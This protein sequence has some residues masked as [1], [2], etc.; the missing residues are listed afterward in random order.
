MKQ[1]NLFSSILVLCGICLVAIAVLIAGRNL[2]EEYRAGE[3]SADALELLTEQ[4]HAQQQVSE[5]L[6]QADSPSIEE[7]V[8]PG[9]DDSL[10]AYTPMP[11]IE[12]EGIS[13][14]GYLEI[15]ALELILP[16]I[17]NSTEDNLETA[18]CRFYGTAYQKNFVIGGHRYRRHFRNIHTLRAGD[19]VR[20]TDVTGKEF[21]YEV[22]DL[23][24]FNA[25]Q[26]EALCSGDWDLTLYTCTVGGYSRVA[27]RC[28]LK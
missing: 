12:I 11:E 22:L 4:I 8:K 6:P 17:S 18:P 24:T 13:Y 9:A 5:N 28:L 20:F 2:W 27:V 1:R 14:I 21:V 7:A 10:N 3:R 23:E 16:V 26:A 25:Y 19:V 15:P